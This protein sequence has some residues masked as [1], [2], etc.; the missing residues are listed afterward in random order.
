MDDRIFKLDMLG[1]LGLIGLTLLL[2]VGWGFVV[3][4][5]WN[6]TMPYIF[7]LPSISIWQGV[8]LSFLANALIK[9]THYDWKNV[10]K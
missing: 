9:S 8:M 10:G 3:S 1:C 4:F 5:A 7:G 6:E 2:I